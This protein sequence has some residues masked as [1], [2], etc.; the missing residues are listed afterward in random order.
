MLK[1]QNIRIGLPHAAG[2]PYTS[3]RSMS[4]GNLT[5]AV[6]D[7]LGIVASSKIF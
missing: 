5:L 2:S 6:S 4:H 3:V 7:R 1:C